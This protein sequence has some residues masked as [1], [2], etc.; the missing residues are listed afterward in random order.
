MYTISRGDIS[1]IGTY[2]RSRLP[3]QQ[4]E[5]D[6]VNVNHFFPLVAPF[7]AQLWQ[8]PCSGDARRTRTP[9]AP[10]SGSWRWAEPR[11]LF[12]D[13]EPVVLDVDGHPT[14]D[15]TP[16]WQEGEKG[17]LMAFANT[18]ETAGLRA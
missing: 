12:P 11:R 5:M 6:A 9:F 14:N 17:A 15:P 7:N 3:P 10:D 8:K 16:M 18:L 4:E 13:G 1:A 2:R